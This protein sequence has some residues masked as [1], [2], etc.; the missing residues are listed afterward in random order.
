MANHGQLIGWVDRVANETASNNINQVIFTFLYQFLNGPMRSSSY[1]ELVA[2]QYGLSGTGTDFFDEN[3]PFGENAF[4]VFRIL[5]GAN[6]GGNS[7]RA[8]DYYVLIQWADTQTFGTSPGD[9]G[10]AG[11]SVSNDGI[12]IACAWRDDGNSPWGGST[13]ADGTDSKSTPVWVSGSSTVRV[14]PMANNPGGDDNA[15]KAQCASWHDSTTTSV[16]YRCH[17]LADRDNIW[18][19]VDAS[20]DLD[21]DSY[22]HIGVY[23]PLPELSASIDSPFFFYTNKIDMD[24]TPTTTYGNTAGTG[25]QQ[26][27]VHGPSGSL[28]NIANSFRV[29]RYDDLI[30]NELNPNPLASNTYLSYKL[31]VICYRSP[32]FGHL[33]FIDTTPEVSNIP[34]EVTNAAS[35]SCVFGGSPLLLMPWSGSH[36]RSFG[37]RTGRQFQV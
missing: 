35:S 23:E 26:G 17:F 20:D 14:F 25:N 8:Q 36:P 7:N 28:T 4:A 18:G 5:S 9:P 33:G 37:T 31:P 22:F 32:D 10:E 1:S 13:N 3:S 11:G 29:E 2:L 6:A 21:Y 30:A 16:P 34:I 12:A 19:F 24:Y 15:T 27:M